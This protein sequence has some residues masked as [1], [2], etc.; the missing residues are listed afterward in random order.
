MRLEGYSFDDLHQMATAEFD[1]NP[2]VVADLTTVYRMTKADYVES[3]KEHGVRR[4][5]ARIQKMAEPL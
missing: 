2:E 4:D 5:A 3:L 1:G